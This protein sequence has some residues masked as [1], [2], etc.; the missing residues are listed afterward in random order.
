VR[1]RRRTAQDIADDAR[2]ATTREEVEVLG[3]EAK[4]GD[5]KKDHVV[6]DPDQPNVTE[7]LGDYLTHLW[8]ELPLAGGGSG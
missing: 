7:E 3:K 2:N 5:L 4:D 1:R 8:Q 6:T